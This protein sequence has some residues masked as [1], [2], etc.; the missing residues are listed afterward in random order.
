[1]DTMWWDTHGRR[2]LVREMAGRGANWSGHTLPN[3]VRSA[4]SVDRPD[5]TIGPGDN[6]ATLA[7]VTTPVFPPG[8]FRWPVTAIVVLSLIV[9]AG[10]GNSRVLGTAGCR[11]GVRMMPAT[12]RQKVVEHGDHHQV[13]QRLLH[14]AVLWG[15]S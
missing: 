9:A 6:V 10:C 12:P 2:R 13:M 7:T 11:V 14:R 1:M 15:E 3:N 5:P 4:R 8:R